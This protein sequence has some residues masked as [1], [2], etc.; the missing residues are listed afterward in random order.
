MLCC[1]RIA[2]EKPHSKENRFFHTMAMNTD[3]VNIYLNA[4]IHVLIL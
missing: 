2:L 1:R 3:V 4:S